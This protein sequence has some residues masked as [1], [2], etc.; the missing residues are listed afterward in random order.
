[1][2]IINPMQPARKSLD[3]NQFLDQEIERLQEE[4]GFKERIEIPLPTY[5][6]AQYFEVLENFTNVLAR[7]VQ[8][9]TQLQQNLQT[10]EFTCFSNL[11]TEL[12]LKIWGFSFIS[13]TQP[14]VHCVD[15]VNSDT[16]RESF[17]SNQPVSSILH[18]NHESRSHYFRNTQLTFAF[19]TYLN[20]ETDIFYIPD[21]DDRESSFPKFLD[22]PHSQKIQKLAL[23]KDFFCDIPLPGHFSIKHVAI[24]DL[25]SDW[26]QLLIV[27]EDER[28]GEEIWKDTSVVFKEFTAREK[29]KRAE[30]SYARQYCKTLNVIME[31]YEEKIMDFR[32][33]QL[34]RGADYIDSVP[35]FLNP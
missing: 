1:M 4:I 35:A 27:F 2:K 7:N 8:Q 23:R 25:L 28:L 22:F 24:L 11:P 15:I 3:R 31:G 10:R 5:L 13:D 34:E 18:A 16:N 32:F 6:K 12:R 29:R 33:G 21:F 17:I 20:F 19:R 26:K 14:R 9:K 30:R